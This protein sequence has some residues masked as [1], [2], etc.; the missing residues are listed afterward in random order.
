M[1]KKEETKI[2]TA[3][4]V[5]AKKG[6]I[7]AKP[8]P[9]HSDLFN[10]DIEVENTHAKE[11]AQMLSSNADDEMYLYS[12]IIYENCPLFRDKTLLAEYELDDPYMLARTIY[13]A[14]VVEFMRLGNY[15]L[16]VYGANTADLAR[17]IKK[18]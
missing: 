18:K 8:A 13:G 15:I 4:M 11:F 14:N 16:D 12:R 3:Q 2:L 9:F 1:T 10:A 5:L 6:I 17:K 7:D